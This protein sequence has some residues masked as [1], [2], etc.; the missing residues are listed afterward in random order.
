MTMKKLLGSFITHEHTLNIDKEEIE[1]TKKKKKN[2]PFESS[3]KKRM[4]TLM[5]LLTRN[6]KKFFK[7]RVGG[8]S[9]RMQEE[10]KRGKK[11]NW[12]L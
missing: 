1:T 7:N 3:C 12:D 8:S 10:K 6:F 4:M 5:T 2:W 9:P 11:I